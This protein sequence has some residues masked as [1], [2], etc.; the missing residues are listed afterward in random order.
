LRE[1]V[2]VAGPGSGRWRIVL[3]TVLTFPLLA[4]CSGDTPACD[5]AAGYLHEARLTEAANAY[6][7]A[8]RL[9]EGDCAADG[10]EQVSDLQGDSLAATAT[11]HAAESAADL[12][13][14]QAAYETALAIDRGN[15]EAAAGLRR[16][17]S[18]PAT[19]SQI[20]FTAQ[21]L[22]DEGYAEAA[23]SEV[24][25]VLSRHP[26]ETVPESLVHLQNQPRSAAPAPA[27]TAAPAAE[28]AARWD[29]TDWAVVTL[30]LLLVL[31]SV[32]GWRAVLGLRSGAAC[33]ASELSLVRQRAEQLD[34]D[35]RL[36]EQ[37]IGSTQ[38]DLAA[39]KQS[40]ARALAENTRQSESASSRLRDLVQDATRLH[41]AVQDLEAA[42]QTRRREIRQVLL[43]LNK[44][45]EREPMLVAEQFE[46]SGNPEDRP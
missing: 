45:R 35:M 19:I 13:G 38:S 44:L 1:V 17:T 22:D 23:R 5:R 18:R 42:A 26:E 3:V 40:L 6:A 25:R 39:T 12:R 24:I 9:A 7:E 30:I 20:W 46:P 8:K 10:L 27:T 29:W 28:P 4:A 36:R 11:G 21:R 2:A 14:A 34:R 43:A 16:V 31:A 33:T 32:I 41:R 15:A 37:E